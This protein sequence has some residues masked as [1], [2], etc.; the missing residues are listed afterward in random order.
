MDAPA[1]HPHPWRCFDQLIALTNQAAL[2]AIPQSHISTTAFTPL[3]NA[4]RLRE[5]ADGRVWDIDTGHDLMIT[6]PHKVA[7]LL[8]RVAV[9]TAG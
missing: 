1:A 8:D 7:D 4:D 3:R 9:L 2:Q 5:K 6:Q